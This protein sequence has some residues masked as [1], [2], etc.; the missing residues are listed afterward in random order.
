M[1]FL[2]RLKDD[3]VFAKSAYRALKMTTPIAKNP[4]R[5]FPVVLSELADRFGDAPALIS[6]RESF[7]YRTLGERA[8][9]YARWAQ[10]ENLAK[11][12]TVCLLMPNRPEYLASFYSEDAFYSD[13]AIPNGVR[14]Q[15]ALLAYF[16]RLLRRFPDWSWTQRGSQPLKDGFLNGWHATIPM[17]GRVVEIDGVCSVQLRGGLIYRNVVYFDR[18]ELL[19]ALDPMPTPRH[20]IFAALIGAIWLKEGFGLPRLAGAAS[21]V[22]GVAA[23]KL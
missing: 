15:R 10:Q 16:E 6:D 18:S 12:E 9:R 23:L 21:V 13:P 5:V 4:T 2:D 11:G 19:A 22:A 1:S 20:G 17:G 8:N 7:S 3:F 14:G